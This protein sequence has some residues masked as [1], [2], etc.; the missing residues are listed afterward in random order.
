MERKEKSNRKAA[1]GLR[2]GLSPEFKGGPALLSSKL[3]YL[4][5]S[6]VE[7]GIKMTT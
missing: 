7:R 4:H 1:N 5:T 6:S 3:A 2:N